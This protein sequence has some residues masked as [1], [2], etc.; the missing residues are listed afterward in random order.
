ML[1]NQITMNYYYDPSSYFPYLFID[2]VQSNEIDEIVKRLQ[3]INIKVLKVYQEPCFPAKDGKK[4]KCLIRLQ[5]QDGMRRI[6]P[7]TKLIE[8]IIKSKEIQLEKSINTIELN[9]GKTNGSQ[10]LFTYN[11]RNAVQSR[12][13]DR[14]SLILEARN[15]VSLLTT[16]LETLS[17]H[18]STLHSSIENILDMELERETK[19][20]QNIR[21][22]INKLEKEAKDRNHQIDRLNKVKMI[23]GSDEDQDLPQTSYEI[24]ERDCS[25]SDLIAS[26]VI[27][28]QT[29]NIIVFGHSILDDQIIFSTIKEQFLSSGVMLKKKD[30]TILTADKK[31]NLKNSPI[32]DMIRSRKYDYL[33]VGPHPHSLKGKHLKHS[34]EKFMEINA[35]NTK[36]YDT[37]HM[38]LSKDKIE[39][40]AKIMAIDWLEKRNGT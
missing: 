4:Y 26:E 25:E 20:L 9:E 30:I 24:E 5:L 22:F 12:T 19:E 8:K 10:I 32:A 11:K 36:V 16:Q 21:S 35:I 1:T 40:Y 23:S 27:S 37:L 7:D 33:M 29:P 18:I 28:C 31:S 39:S 6:V 34:W 15:E 3:A 17:E 38:N 13:D 2:N 14:I